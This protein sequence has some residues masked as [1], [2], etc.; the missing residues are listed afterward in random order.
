MSDLNKLKE[1]AERCDSMRVSVD[2]NAAY[3]NFIACI[4]PKDVVALFEQLEAAEAL[5]SHLDLAVRKA[6][7]VSEAL[8]RKAEVAEQRI[9][10]L[11][12]SLVSASTMQTIHREACQKAESE[13]ARRDKAAGEPVATLRVRNEDNSLHGID[14]NQLGDA[15]GDWKLYLA[16]PAVLPPEV[17]DLADYEK[18]NIRFMSKSEAAIQGA[19]WMRE[20]VKALGAQPEKVVVLPEAFYPDGDID[21]PMVVNVKDVTATLD[22]AGVKWKEAE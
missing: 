16:Q 8:R 3:G 7:G 9:A 17:T 1:L 13:I 14:W 5:N 20:Q 15:D 2:Q 11:E 22:A 19:N 18:D 21:C 10:E 4:E 12:S 6:E